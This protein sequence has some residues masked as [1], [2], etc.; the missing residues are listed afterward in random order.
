[1]KTSFLDARHHARQGGDRLRALQGQQRALRHRDDL[2]TLADPGLDMGDVASL[3]GAIDDDK[4]VCA[5]V[6]E[7]QV[8]DDAAFVIEQQPV[9]LLAG[10]QTDHVHGNQGLERGCGVSTHQTQLAH[11]RD[12]EQAGGGA[13]VVV[14][15]HEAGRV[16]HRHR[17]AGKRHHA[18]TELHMQRIQRGG[19]QRGVMGC[20]HAIL[21]RGKLETWHACHGLPSLSALP[22]RFA[23]P[24]SPC[25][26][27][28][29]GLRVAPSV[30]PAGL[31]PRRLSPVRKRPF[32]RLS[33]LLPE[34]S[35]LL[36]EPPAP[37]APALGAGS[38]LTR[39]DSTAGPASTY[40]A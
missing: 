25:L 10:L 3:A 20:G 15:G 16:L 38:L 17:I 23:G 35:G 40:R 39:L 13:G 26:G 36:A 8:V 9:A 1:M 19:E 5:P 27:H 18:G 4:E 2:A 37:S 33:V 12:V 7:H 11:V 22:E 31:H 30:D 34:R 24:A 28:S 32:R 21:L 14:F 6:D 29:G